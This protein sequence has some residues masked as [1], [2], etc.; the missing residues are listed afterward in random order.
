M[1][2]RPPNDEA[3]V[4]SA[5]AP[6][7]RRAMIG[8]QVRQILLEQI[9]GGTYEPGERLDETRIARDLGVSQGTVREALR[10]LEGL[11]FVD[12]A[13]YQGTRVRRARTREELAAIHPVREALETL[14]AKT[15]VPNL[16]KDPAPLQ[17]AIAAM[18][19]AAKAGDA[20][21]YAEHNADFHRTIVVAS[22]NPA[23]LTAW[24][25]LAVEMRSL[26]TTL[27]TVVDLKVA[28]ERHAP[29]LAAVLDGDI[30]LVCSLLRDHQNMYKNLSLDQLANQ[31]T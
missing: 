28:A 18:R 11:G 8:S 9:L 1:A 12:S 3:T 16:A 20:R 6:S 19:R 17:D 2:G 29:I 13:P 23:L 4:G 21:T 24:E 5:S 10:A 15:A 22:G 30:E 14:A 31:P 25:S 27:T 26:A 7:I